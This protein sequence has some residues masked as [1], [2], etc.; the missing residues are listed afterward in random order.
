MMREEEKDED[1]SLVRAVA[2]FA[3]L[4]LVFQVFYILELLLNLFVN[5]WLPFLDGWSVFD[6]GDYRPLWHC[7][8][9]RSGP[10]AFSG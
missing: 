3:E 2:I 10:S 6:S 8:A 5:W 1:S 4:D 7:P 9:W